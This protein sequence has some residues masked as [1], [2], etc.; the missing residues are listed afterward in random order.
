MTEIQHVDVFAE[1]AHQLDVVLHQQDPDTSFPHG[2]LDHVAQL[3]GLPLVE[4]R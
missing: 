2:P 1:S 4:P 3:A